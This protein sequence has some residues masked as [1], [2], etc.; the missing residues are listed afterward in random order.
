[1]ALRMKRAFSPPA[2]L[3]TKVD[4]AVLAVKPAAIEAAIAELPPARFYLS[5]AAGRT[6]R[7]L[8]AAA[9][10]GAAVVRAMPNT[11]AAIGLGVT[12]LCANDSV[13]SGDR[14]LAS[15][16]MQAVGI[17]EWLEDEAAIDA[18][19]AVSGSGPA[20]VFLLIECLTA[21]AIDV[22]LDPAMAERLATATVRGAGAYAARSGVDAA[23]LRHQVTSPNGTTAAALEVLLDNGSLETL[24]RRAVRAAARRSRELGSAGAD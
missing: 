10:P 4:V 20:Y 18:V 3:H 5:I 9:G 24:I 11:P 22:G 15:S 21:A 12:A 13:Q 6:L 16:L 2:G 17:V 23:A 1:M 14:A 8:E 7:E 19:T